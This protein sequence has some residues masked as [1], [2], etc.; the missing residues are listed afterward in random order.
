[1]E[2]W[3]DDN[4]I[5][6]YSTHNECESVAAARFIRTLK[7]KI[8]KKCTANSNKSYLDCLNKLVDEYNNIYNHYINKRFINADYSLLTVEFESICK[9]P[10]SK[11]G[12]RFKIIK[13]KNIFSKVTQIVDQKKYLRLI[14]C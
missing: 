4:D 13:Y 14:L 10:K 6:M 12:D 11:V 2:K 1:M 7:G 9:A 8:Y 5:L 3:L